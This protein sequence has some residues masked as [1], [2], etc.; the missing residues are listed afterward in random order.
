MSLSP[1]ALT[2]PDPFFLYTLAAALFLALV[3]LSSGWRRGDVL[4]LAKPEGLFHVALAVTLGVGLTALSGR[5]DAFLPD[6]FS[7]AGLNLLPLYVVVLA[8]GPSAGLLAAALFAAFAT[9]GAV[10]G[11]PE[12]LLA[13]ELATLGWLAV[14]PSPRRFRWAGSVNV[15]CAY[16]LAWLTGGS[17]LLAPLRAAG[18]FWTAQLE[19]HLSAL[20]GLLLSACLLGL[21]SPAFYRRAFPTSRLAS[22]QTSLPDGEL[23]SG[24]TWTV[25]AGAAPENLPAPLHLPQ[26]RQRLTLPGLTLSPDGAP[27]PRE[28]PELSP[29]RFTHTVS[30]RR[31]RRAAPKVPHI[32]ELKKRPRAR[33]GSASSAVEDF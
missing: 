14:A 12:A 6:G 26:G 9:S 13:L 7:L 29:P 11:W 24:E 31:K 22:F 3:A 23:V 21:L 5:A 25:R 20:P 10:P 1:S 27:K 33:Q 18:A 15:L 2:N 17:A 19:Q 16:A 28:R 4:A 32:E 30:L 8:Y